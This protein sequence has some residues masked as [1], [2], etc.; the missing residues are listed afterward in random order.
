M[1]RSG[2]RRRHSRIASVLCAV[3]GSALLLP[4]TTASAAVAQAQ[5]SP[6]VAAATPGL[7]SL[8]SCI[9]GNRRLLLLLLIDE[10]GSL[11]TTD[12]NAQR[13]AG[14]QIAVRQLARLTESVPGRIDIRLQVAG[15]SVDFRPG[16]GWLT[17]GPDTVGQVDREIASFAGR[18]TGL[19]TDYVNALQGAQ[20][21]L[22]E[23]AGRSGREPHCEALVWFTDGQISIEDRTS[24]ARREAGR[25]RTGQALFKDYAPDIR[26]DQEGGGKR[27]EDAGRQIL[28][29]S[30]GVTTQL[31]A[32]G[33]NMTVVALT[34]EIAKPDV[35]LLGALATGEQ[36]GTSCGSLG[37]P[38]A[39][40]LLTASDLTGLV[41]AF[42]AL[43]NKIAGGHGD[44]AHPSPVCALAACEQGTRRFDI[45]T[46]L[47]RFHVLAQSQIEGLQIQLVAPKAPPV[48]IAPT[49]AGTAKAGN[50]PI[51]YAWV[52]PTALTLDVDYPGTDT[53]W[54]G[55]WSLTFIDPTGRNPDA[56]GRASIYLFG[57][58]VPRLVEKPEFRMATK[59]PVTIEL[60][61][62]AGTPLVPGDFTG[63]LVLT[64]QVTDP[65][66]TKTVTL[67][68]PTLQ[69][70]GRYATTYE[71]PDQLG[72]P[73]VNLT[74]NLQVST[75][76]GI[77]LAPSSTTTAVDVLPPIGF[78]I[79]ETHK[80]ALG[81]L[82]GTKPKGDENIGVVELKG[83]D[84]SAGC[85]W[86]SGLELPV[87]P[88]EAGRLETLVADGHDD[89]GRC[90]AVPRGGT[91]RLEVAVR[92]ASA[93]RGTASGRVTVQTT[94]ENSDQVVPISV[95]ITLELRRP[96][97]AGLVVAIL[98]G[99]TAIGLL[100]PLLAMYV[101]NW[102]N[103]RFED[104]TQLSMAS[105]PVRVSSYGV[106]RLGQGDK[107]PNGSIVG[108]GDFKPVQEPAGRTR[109]FEKAG[110][111]FQA[112]TPRSPLA[113][114][115][116]AVQGPGPVAGSEPQPY[117][118]DRGRLPLA[119]GNAWFFSPAGASAGP[120]SDRS[121]DR[122]LTGTLVCF[123]ES[124]TLVRA[125]AVLND[126]IAGHLPNR[127]ESLRSKVDAPPSDGEDTKIADGE[128]LQTEWSDDSKA[129]SSSSSRASVVDNDD[130]WQ[131]VST[132]GRSRP[133][134][135]RERLEEDDDS[136]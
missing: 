136:W 81:P 69:P 5:P 114:P 116:G 33:V 127:L 76:S 71:V 3:I 83:S 119:L 79:V 131:E 88:R 18:N 26:L 104:P 92:P 56:V 99:L 134:A 36:A 94:S 39:G 87:A 45:D 102:W 64:A 70:N 2:S 65:L 42:D 68:K 101:T 44:G 80:L 72:S 135:P 51:S 4:F 67:A 117:S 17:L 97:K 132:A 115:Y 29:E 120:E 129:R 23:E 58:V 31:R 78:P 77:V 91:A 11:E 128:V 37:A 95:P 90:L 34:R 100:L 109:T 7:S 38:T 8:A 50:V 6:A 82:V 35:D 112:V 46:S 59:S 43:A 30:G 118:G 24:P 121:G 10:S 113:S 86:V 108:Y 53:N 89:R 57:D 49:G 48:I 14:A 60:Q 28:C 106:E 111:D 13:V 9:A 32:A 122:P 103:A 123:G 96:T 75:K 66:T 126:S 93:A 25:D 47:R 74:L 27:A 54:T 55:Q 52:A 16:T 110:F 41:D 107:V 12:P 40:T 105:V 63:E 124:D 22:Q 133:A 20:E 130:D 73:R 19:D 98:A 125:I 21:S 15:F 84:V 62:Q 85:A 61:R 1:M